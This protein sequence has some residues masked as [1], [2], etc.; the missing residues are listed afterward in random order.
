MIIYINTPMKPFYIFLTAYIPLLSCLGPVQQFEPEPSH[1]PGTEKPVII[2]AHD[3]DSSRIDQFFSR[4]I[5]YHKETLLSKNSAL[6]D[7]F[8]VDNNLLKKDSSNIQHFLEIKLLHDLLT[9]QGAVNGSAG[10][11]LNI[12]YFWHWTKPNPRHSIQSLKNKKALNSIKPPSG[13][14]KYATHADIDRTPGLFWS[15]L[16]SPEPLYYHEACDT[17][18]TFGWC[19]EREMAYV[20]MMEILGHSGEIIVSGNHSWSEI[21]AQFVKEDKQKTKIK[22]SVDNTFNG[23]AWNQAIGNKTVGPTT[24]W[25]NEK[26][27]STEEK[28]KV[29]SIVITP[30]VSSRIESKLIGFLSTN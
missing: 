7:Q 1:S 27:S 22:L 12:P 15:E 19:S 11:I 6:Y 4:L 9:A 16:F 30:A 8:C 26:A 2:S 28:T 17:F 5:I 13:Y 25:Y 18:N 21:E 24:K 3:F 29:L 20:C 14:G 23:F 10:N